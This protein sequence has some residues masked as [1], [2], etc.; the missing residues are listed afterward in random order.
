MERQWSGNDCV[1]GKVTT[2]ADCYFGKLEER[3]ERGNVMYGPKV[4]EMTACA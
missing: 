2:F 1:I 4:G 3:F